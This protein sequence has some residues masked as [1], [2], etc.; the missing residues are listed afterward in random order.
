[1]FFAS[2]FEPSWNDLPG[3]RMAS[4]PLIQTLIAQ[5]LQGQT[6]NHNLVAGSGL[7]WYP[8]EK[9]P[10]NYTLRTPSGGMV[11]LGLPVTKDNRQVLSIGAFD[12]SGVYRLMATSATSDAVLADAGVAIAVTPDL[13]ES[14]DLSTLSDEQIDA[15]LGFRPTHATAGVDGAPASG[16]DRFRRE[17]TLYLL[18]AVLALAV[19]ESVLAFLCG[20]SW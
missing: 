17:W 1:M 19:F 3:A 12:Q 9:E 13:R 4:V 16:L 10:Q 15:R 7:T 11:R 14:V 6:L 18:A 2:A 8:K 20:K 5:L